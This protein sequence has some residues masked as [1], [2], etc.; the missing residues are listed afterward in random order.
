MKRLNWLLL[1]TILLI[2]TCMN[3][4]A[5]GRKLWGGDANVGGT[6]TANI[7]AATTQ[8]KAATVVLGAS[9]I[10][11]NIPA[12]SA[13]DD[14]KALIYSD[15]V[16]DVALRAVSLAGTSLADIAD[17]TDAGKADG[18]LLRYDAGATIWRATPVSVA[19]PSLASI[20]NVT[21]DTKADGYVLAWDASG[22]VWSATPASGGTGTVADLDDITNV[23]TTGKSVGD[24]L[25]WTGAIWSATPQASG[26]GGASQLNDLSDV[27]I[28]GPALNEVLKY[29][30]SIWVNGTSPGGGGGVRSRTVVVGAADSIDNS[31]ADFIASG[32]NDDV[33]INAALAS[34]DPATGGT[35][36]LLEGTYL[37]SNTIQMTTDTLNLIGSGQNNTILR[38]GWSSGGTN[39]VM[40]YVDD[41]DLTDTDDM[42][43]AHMALDGQNDIY[44]DSDADSIKI[45]GA[46]RMHV[47]DL[48]IYDSPAIGFSLRETGPEQR[49]NTVV[50]N[51]HVNNSVQSNFDVESGG[52]NTTFVNCFATNGSGDGFQTAGDR[53]TFINC[54]ADTNNAVGFTIGGLGSVAIGCIAASNGEDGFNL[55][56]QYSAVR[57]SVSHNNAVHGVKVNNDNNVVEG[58]YLFDNG[59]IGILFGTSSSEGQAVGNYSWSNDNHGIR[60]FNGSNNVLVAANYLHENADFGLYITA[61]DYTIVKDNV[62]YGND[63]GDIRNGDKNSD[64]NGTIIQDNYFYDPDAGVDHIDIEWSFDIWIKGNHF[65]P[66]GV[67]TGYPVSIDD[68]FSGDANRIFMQ[69]NVIEPGYPADYFLD[70]GQ[71]IKPIL[72]EHWT[73]EAALGNTMIL[74]SSSSANIGLATDDISTVNNVITVG[75]GAPTNP[76]ANSWDIYSDDRYKENITPLPEAEKGQLLEA[77]RNVQSVTFDYAHR[78]EPVFDPVKYAST[79]ELADKRIVQV[80]DTTKLDEGAVVL[81]D[82]LERFA[83]D[84]ADWWTWKQNP[85]RNNVLGIRVRDPN[86]PD[87][88]KSFDDRGQPT[89]LNTSQLMGYYHTAI[90]EL[91]K[92][93]EALEA[94]NT[95]EPIRQ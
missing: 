81:D 94:A 5:Q 70:A 9:E 77:M 18:Y 57:T 95:P 86:L 16:G 33:T 92:R 39:D 82:G 54:L 15:T 88:F 20:G 2:V 4:H 67:E 10:Q 6:F 69:D 3:S 28:S 40:I 68:Y 41:A 37:L 19:V 17:V 75:S 47:H 93:V 65:R 80:T 48:Y 83:I 1:A 60:V 59:L 42:E 44:T 38:R 61:A 63:A 76:I 62:F 72:L 7:L 45:V 91:L 36:F 25:Y 58:C 14:G 12:T 73:G 23:D 89:G 79:V 32:T 34:I 11:I 29:N 53:T 22:M 64:A 43:I 50:Q 55:T 26:G 52:D 78:T 85:N 51:V 66:N 56:G 8:V 49:T 35:V 30:G 24:V 31:A 27:T 74:S 71:A 87:R 46:N 84:Y 90:N 13:A 21:T